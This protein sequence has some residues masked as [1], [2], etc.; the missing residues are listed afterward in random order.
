MTKLNVGES[1]PIAV[2]AKDKKGGDVI[3]GVAK[4]EE[5]AIT[6]EPNQLWTDWTKTHTVD[7]DGFKKSFLF[8][9]PRLKDVNYFC[10]CGLVEEDSGSEHLFRIGKDPVTITMPAGGKLYYF[11]NDYKF[12]YWNNKG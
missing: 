6:L 4:G 11:A 8:P 1:T 5:Y 12:A 2:I 7:A 3:L 10:L 9:Q